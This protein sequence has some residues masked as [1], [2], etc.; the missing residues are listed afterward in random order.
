MENGISGNSWPEQKAFLSSVQSWHQFCSVLIT[1]YAMY[2]CYWPVRTCLFSFSSS[3]IRQCYYGVVFSRAGKVQVQSYDYRLS[4]VMQITR[5][6]STNSVHAEADYLASENKENDKAERLVHN[7]YLPKA[8]RQLNEQK[9]LDCL[10]CK[11]GE[12]S[13]V[14]LWANTLTFSQWHS[15]ENISDRLILQLKPPSNQLHFHLKSLTP[16][17]QNI[18]NVNTNQHLTLCPAAFEHLWYLHIQG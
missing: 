16:V 10:K 13:T 4:L 6:P 18:K 9:R 7:N 2:G 1:R 5:H 12:H 3:S 11:K 8:F 17:G 15:L 14:C